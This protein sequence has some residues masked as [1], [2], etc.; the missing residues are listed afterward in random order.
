M[1][2]LNDHHKKGNL[3]RTSLIIFSILVAFQLTTKPNECH[4]TNLLELTAGPQVK[5]NDTQPVQVVAVA[6]S[7]TSP[8]LTKTPAAKSAGDKQKSNCDYDKS[9][10]TE[11]NQ[12]GELILRAKQ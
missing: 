8:K 7:A 6:A 9:K 11:C 3:S 12:A 10:W 5:P 4:P 2:H 1:H